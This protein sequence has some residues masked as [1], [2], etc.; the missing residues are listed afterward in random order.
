[1]NIATTEGKLS[2]GRP[3]SNPALVIP[4]Q[5]SN[6]LNT[7]SQRS[8]TQNLVPHYDAGSNSKLPFVLHR[9]FFFCS[10]D[11]E[12]SCLDVAGQLDI[13][14]TNIAATAALNTAGH[15]IIGGY[16]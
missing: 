8:S 7:T 1:M 12:F 6:L 4:A 5:A 2:S 10:G 9:D 14:G 11:Q 15:V 13:S 3:F 16:I